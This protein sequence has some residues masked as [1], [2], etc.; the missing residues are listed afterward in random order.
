MDVIREEEHTIRKMKNIEF[1]EELPKSVGNTALGNGSQSYNHGLTY[2]YPE[3]HNMIQDG[4]PSLSQRYPNLI[5]IYH[6]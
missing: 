1:V 4:K 5:A 3:K 2:N 6:T